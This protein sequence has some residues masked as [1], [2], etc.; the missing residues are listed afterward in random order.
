[1]NKHRHTFVEDYDGMVGF[2]FSREV[3]EKSLKVYL[4]KFADDDLLRVLAPRLSDT[5]ITQMFELMSHL[6]KKHLRDEEYHSL[7][8]KDVKNDQ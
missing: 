4:Q 3:D 8:L 7:F 2:G 6:L 5:E 1:M